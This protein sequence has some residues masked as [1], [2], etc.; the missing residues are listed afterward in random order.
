MAINRTG[1][2]KTNY[3]TQIS[4][5]PV[6]ELTYTLAWDQ[7]L[8]TG[9]SLATVSFTAAARRNDPTPITVLGSGIVNL[10]NA[11]VRLSGGQANKLYVI[12]CAI[13]TTEGL[14]D[15]RQFRI[16]VEKRQA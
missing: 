6:A 12:T 9:D 3:T 14:T 8:E 7:W 15:S 5:D 4:K 13:T 2:E 16:L 10:T 11:Y 1:F